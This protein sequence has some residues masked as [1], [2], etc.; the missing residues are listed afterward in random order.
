MGID[1]SS[2]TRRGGNG[3]EYIEPNIYWSGFWSQGDGA[4]FE[5][6]FRSHRACAASVKA[7]APEDLELHRIAEQIDMATGRWVDPIIAT[8]KHRGH[9]YHYNSVDIDVD[10]D[11]ESDE[12]VTAFRNGPDSGIVDEA[13]RDLMKWFYRQ[14]EAEY[15]Y[16]MS[17]ES[18]EE[19]M[20]ANEY[21]F[22]ADGKRIDADDL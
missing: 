13:I 6:T 16:R 11:T 10:L 1:I 12:A 22:T 4:C 21:T 20:E 18:I 9:Y 2:H 17:D 5:G 7:H 8:I 14:L 19:S 3:R 15:N